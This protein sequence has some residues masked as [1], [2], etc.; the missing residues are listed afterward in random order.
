MRRRVETGA[1]R[2]TRSAPA[3][4]KT[5]PNA[6]ARLRRKAQ[7]ILRQLFP[8][9]RESLIIKCWMSHDARWFMVVATTFG[10]EAAMCLN[11]VA[12]REEGRVEARRPMHRL[13]LPPVH[14]A[15]KYLRRSEPRRPMMAS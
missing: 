13:Q 14:S 5:T 4:R 2:E 11:R 3:G 12:V 1:I 8:K 9:E 15:S 7:Q 6:Q 10:L